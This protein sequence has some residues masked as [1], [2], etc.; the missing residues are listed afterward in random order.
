VLLSVSNVT[1]NTL[2]DGPNN[3]IQGS[4]SST[5]SLEVFEVSLGN[6]ASQ[7][8]FG[9]APLFDITFNSLAAG[10]SPLA[11]DTVAN[12]GS[13]VFDA[14]G[15]VFSDFTY[16]DSSVTITGGSGGSVQ[17]PEMDSTSAAGA[18]TF[19]AGSLFVIGGRRRR[20]DEG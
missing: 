3:S 8:G 12:G 18:L 14:I 4:T 17:A 5:G 10:T 16:V 20:N 1:Y 6:L 19:L 13:T 11:F 2:L 7:S 15:N 9:T